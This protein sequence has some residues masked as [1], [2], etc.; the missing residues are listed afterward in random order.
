MSI[1]PMRDILSTALAGN[2]AVG[3]FEP[4]DSYSLRAVVEAAE[5]ARSPVILGFGCVMADPAWYRDGGLEELAATGLIAA[6]RTT[7]PVAFLL[8]EARDFDELTRGLQCGFNA[9]MMDSSHLPLEEHIETTRRVVQAAQPLGVDV[10]GALGHLPEADGG[11][12]TGHQGTASLTD[13]DE[14]AMFVERTGVDALAVSVGN[15]HEL[16][17]GEV[18]IDVGRLRSIWDATGV[19]LV[20]HGGSSFPAAMVP[21]AIQCGVAKFNV[22][23]VLKRVFLNGLTEAVASLPPTVDPHL[24]LGS[25]KPGDVMLPG[26]NLMRLEVLRLMTLY[27]SVGKA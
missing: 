16:E 4:W 20:I 10:E 25:C 23:T 11:G 3:Y 7:V 21:E 27:G 19:P 8:N 2:Y 14:A 22:G 13:P 6:K 24:V 12:E 9:V 17:S 15:V 1:V 5:E 18:S 26:A